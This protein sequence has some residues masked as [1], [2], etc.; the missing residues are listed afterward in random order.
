[1][2][3]ATGRDNLLEERLPRGTR[4]RRCCSPWTPMRSRSPSQTLP[5]YRPR[6][7]CEAP[8]R[9]PG[10]SVEGQSSGRLHCPGHQP[11]VDT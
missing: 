7:A 4:L 2:L 9:C 3:L 1:M 10:N 11:R 8:R 6:S 5:R